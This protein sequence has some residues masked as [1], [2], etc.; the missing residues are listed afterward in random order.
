MVV[1]F[2]G[3]GDVQAG[4]TLIGFKSYDQGRE[5]WQGPTLGLV[6]MDEEP[7]EDIY[8]EGMTRTN[9]GLCPIYITFTPL[10]GMSNVVKRFVID[11]VPGTNVTQMTINDVLH[12]SE[13][14]RQAIINSYPAFE[15]EARTKG[16]PQLGSGRVFPIDENEILV[17]PFTI[18]SHWP[19]I[20][21]M[22]FGWDHPSAGVRLAWDRDAD[23]VYAIAAHRM[24][25]QTPALFAASVKPW[26]GNPDGTQWLPWAWPHDGLQHD[27]GSGEQLAAQYRAQGLRMLPMRATFEDG[28]FGLEAGIASMFDRMQTGRFKVFSHL[29]DWIE[30][31]RL[32][33]RKDGLIVKSGD[34][35]MSA[36]RY[37]CMMLRHAVLQNQVVKSHNAG[38][39][40]GGTWLG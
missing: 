12:Y 6:W 8:T 10:Q 9:V 1:R 29:N 14:Q 2:G 30:E 39:A 31:F 20:A 3:G 27:K 24:R 13:E 37:G 26:G 23:C 19:Q 40:A 5:K 4:D 28:S 7:P 38:R 36:T 21:G 16:I 33:H 11:K 25:Q 15:R 17:A 35:L 32:Y 22:D 34:D 18:P